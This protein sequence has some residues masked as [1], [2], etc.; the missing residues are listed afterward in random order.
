[1]RSA[2]GAR[3]APLPAKTTGG[4]MLSSR[5][6]NHGDEIGKVVQRGCRAAVNATDQHDHV[7]T[8]ARERFR[9]EDRRIL[10]HRRRSLLRRVGTGRH[11][12]R[13]PAP[14]GLVQRKRGLTTACV[15]FTA[16]TALV[17]LSSRLNPTIATRSG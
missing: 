1:M 3:A 9:G 11:S 16:R 15:P 17:T 6:N 7:G 10:Q 12:H 13:H 2:I 14:A 4:R 5:G 8:R